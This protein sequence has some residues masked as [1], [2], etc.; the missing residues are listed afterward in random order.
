MIRSHFIDK[1]N[2]F[3]DVFDLS[4]E[5]LDLFIEVTTSYRAITTCKFENG[6]YRKIDTDKGA[7]FDRIISI[8]EGKRDGLILAFN[9]RRASVLQRD[10]VA[11]EIPVKFLSNHFDEENIKVIYDVL[12]K[13][14]KPIESVKAPET[15][16]L[17]EKRKKDARFASWA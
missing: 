6:A 16:E 8:R 15:K 4:N 5:S 3:G 2:D 10:V 12:K 1:I 11:V 7:F 9:A 14:F 13:H 17:K